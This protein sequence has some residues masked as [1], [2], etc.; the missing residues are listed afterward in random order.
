MDVVEKTSTAEL[1]FAC[2]T[3]TAFMAGCSNV[4]SWRNAESSVDD[5]LRP[6]NHVSLMSPSHIFIA[7]LCTRVGEQRQPIPTCFLGCAPGFLEL[8]C[9]TKQTYV[10]V[11]ESPEFKIIAVLNK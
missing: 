10:H 8:S 1:D 2:W 11:Y 4:E 3:P 5:R 9:V 7:G 6:C